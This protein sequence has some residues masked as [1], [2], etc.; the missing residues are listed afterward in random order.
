MT[1]VESPIMKR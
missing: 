1:F